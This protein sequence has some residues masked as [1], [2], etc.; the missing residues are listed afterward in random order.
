VDES[1][2]SDHE[3]E[4]EEKDDPNL[5]PS[6]SKWNASDTFASYLRRA[7]QYGCLS[8]SVPPY[9]EDEDEDETP[10]LGS[11]PGLTYSHCSSPISDLPTSP[12]FS[13]FSQTSLSIV[14]CP[15]QMHG[16]PVSA[17]GYTPAPPHAQWQRMRIER[18]SKRMERMKKGEWMCARD[19]D[20]DEEDGVDELTEDENDKPFVKPVLKPGEVWDPFG[21]EIEI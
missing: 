17:F 14:S 4:H 5:I 2:A 11:T 10:T 19:E 3:H 18:V 12:L 15:A 6:T 8:T 13:S 16:F 21:D 20:L 1:A 9:D 7:Q